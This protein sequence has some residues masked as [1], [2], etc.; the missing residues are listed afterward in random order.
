MV[1]CR[2]GSFV[3]GDEAWAQSGHSCRHLPEKLT[4]ISLLSAAGRNPLSRPAVSDC[5]E[6]AAGS[7][8]H[9]GR[10]LDPHIPCHNAVCCRPPAICSPRSAVQAPVA[11]PCCG[12]SSTAGRTGMNARTECVLSQ[13]GRRSLSCR[14]QRFE[15]K[16]ARL[17]NC[18]HHRFA[19]WRL[20]A[21]QQPL[22]KPTIKDHSWPNSEACCRVMSSAVGGFGVV[23]RF[24]ASAKVMVTKPTG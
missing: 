8:L 11:N 16:L 24:F 23:E 6:P 20:V 3:F 19:R 7:A 12:C 22:V 1:E 10:H 14:T 9:S 15:M 17:M 13:Y 2:I 5:R 21:H 4:C 18:W